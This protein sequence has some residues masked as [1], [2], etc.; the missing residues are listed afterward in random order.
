MS[1]RVTDFYG[2]FC[3]ESYLGRLYFAGRF[4]PSFSL[5]LQL[6][7]GSHESIV[8]DH[9]DL[10]PSAASINISSGLLPALLP[11]LPFST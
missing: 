6:T 8:V 1:R 11:E 2:D 9:S 3:T 4:I 10:S 7:C 5:F